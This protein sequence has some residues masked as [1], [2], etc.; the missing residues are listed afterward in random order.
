MKKQVKDYVISFERAIVPKDWF[1]G[2]KVLNARIII[3]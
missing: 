2:K 3:L 1:K